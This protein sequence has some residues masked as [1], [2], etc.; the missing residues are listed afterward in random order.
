MRGRPKPAP[1]EVKS[2]KVVDPAMAPPEGLALPTGGAEVEILH[3]ERVE[4]LA[5][6]YREEVAALAPR[7]LKVFADQMNDPTLTM[8]QRAA[9]AREVLDRFQVLVELDL[10][11]IMVR[12]KCEALQGQAA[13]SSHNPAGRIDWTKVPREQQLAIWK[14]KAPEARKIL[15]AS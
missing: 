15:G 10:R 13:F 8:G 5:R 4:A 6:E 7:A 2:P 11:A 9:R 3:R 14:E 1:Q 12:A